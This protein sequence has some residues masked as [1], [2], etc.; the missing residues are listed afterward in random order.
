LEKEPEKVIKVRRHEL[1]VIGNLAKRGFLDDAIPE[2]L[3]L[4]QLQVYLIL[5]SLSKF[6]ESSGVNA[7]FELD[8]ESMYKFDKE[9]K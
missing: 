4:Q 5:K 1:K 9:D 3:E 8:I 6:L 2:N 7:S